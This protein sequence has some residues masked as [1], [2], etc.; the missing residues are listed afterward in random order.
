VISYVTKD[1]FR[2]DPEVAYYTK[3]EKTPSVSLEFRNQSLKAMTPCSEKEI[4][5]I[6]KRMEFCAKGGFGRVFSARIQTPKGSVPVAIKRLPHHTDKEKQNNMGELAFLM[7]CTNHPN[8]VSYKECWLLPN[9]D[10]WIVTEFLEGGTL[11]LAINCHKF[12]EQHIC[13]IA[14]EV[15]S[16]LL[17]LHDLNFAHRDL[18]SANVMTSINGEVKIIDF[19]LACDFHTGPRIQLVGSPYWLPPEMLL[20]QPYHTKV[21][22]WSF[23]VLLLELILGRTPHDHS[24]LASMMYSVMGTTLQE[25]IPLMK[26]SHRPEPTSPLLQFVSQCLTKDPAKRPDPKTLMEDAWLNS[27]ENPREGIEKVL[28]S[29]F[30]S[31]TLQMHGV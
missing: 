27:F 18:K 24:R 29:V 31:S 4:K 9:D 1:S 13:Y 19:G 25:A 2:I 20:K 28:Q 23:G 8:I 6:Y 30:I 22:I 16:G 12:R 14:K 17:F 3:S 10:L 11:D 21:D 26:G 15:L 5:K 7:H